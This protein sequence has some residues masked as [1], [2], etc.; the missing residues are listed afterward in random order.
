MPVRIGWDSVEG[1]PA[2]SSAGTTRCPV[3]IESMPLSTAAW[4]G[5]RSSRSHS[6]RECVMIGTF[7]RP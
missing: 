7:R 6:S 2:A 3:M 5:G 4:N 1:S